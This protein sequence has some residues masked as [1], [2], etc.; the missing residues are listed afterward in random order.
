[1][2]LR[3]VR[4][5]YQ[6]LSASVRKV[7]FNSAQRDEHGSTAPSANSALLEAAAA[8]GKDWVQ[9][10][11]YDEAEAVAE[12]QWSGVIRP[13][14]RD[15]NFTRTLDLAAGH[16]RNTAKFL[17]LGAS[18]VAVDINQSNIEFLENR[19]KD[20][21]SVEIL[22]NNGIDL[23]DIVSESITFIFCFDAMVHFDSDVVRSYIREFRRVLK[24]GCFGLCQYSNNTSNPTGSYREHPGWRNYMSRSLF[25]HWLAKEGFS[26]VSSMYLQASQVIV[27]EDSDSVD[28]ITIFHLPEEVSA[29]GRLRRRLR[30][31]FQ[32]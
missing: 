1:M 31:A 29:A 23:Q 25:E 26:I 17:E 28:A 4:N 13:L 10:P 32:K 18:V 30:D 7:G 14:I 19:F 3:L 8:V 15:Y 12:A 5:A 6:R 11:Y 24:R 21:S 27:D 22:K 16:G 20:S 9:G 2:K